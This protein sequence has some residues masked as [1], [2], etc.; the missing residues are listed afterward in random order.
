MPRISSYTKIRWDKYTSECC[1]PLAFRR[2]KR[3]TTIDLNKVMLIGRVGKDPELK[4]VGGK[5]L[6]NFSL[7]TSYGKGEGAKT[8]WH[9]ITVWEKLADIAMQI[10]HKGDNVYVEGRLSYNIVGEGD[11][12]KV[13][14]QITASN[15]INLTGKPAAGGSGGNASSSNTKS[16]SAPAPQI[17]DQDIPF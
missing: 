2:R 17:D 5:A 9:N 13:F 14:T 15:L 7:A 1:N 3:R 4:T 10:V 6:A 12:R 16:K 11:A 8:E